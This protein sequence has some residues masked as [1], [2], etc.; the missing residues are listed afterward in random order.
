MT[1]RTTA[2]VCEEATRAGEK[3]RD[4]GDCYWKA[5][6]RLKAAETGEE[7]LEARR[8][9]EAAEREWSEAVAAANELTQEMIERIESEAAEE[10]KDDGGK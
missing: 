8:A 5:F 6:R 7:E 3:A 1:E 2:T 4:L 9:L 10:Q